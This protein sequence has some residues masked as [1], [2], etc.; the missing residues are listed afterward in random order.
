M[1]ADSVACSPTG[2]AGEGAA[3][4]NM[5]ALCATGTSCCAPA[6]LEDPIVM[7]HW[8]GCRDEGRCLRGHA[9]G[10]ACGDYATGAWFAARP[11][12]VIAFGIGGPT[13]MADPPPLDTLHPL[14]D[15]GH[16]LHWRYSSACAPSGT[17]PGEL[18]DCCGHRASADVNLNHGVAK[19]WHGVPTKGEAGA[20]WSAVGSLVVVAFGPGGPTGSAD[21]PPP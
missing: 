7:P 4:P 13:W 2:F 11:R 12:Y 15:R 3:R 17:L 9:V 5:R 21:P 16:P 19:S 18:P 8:K 6:R 1:D 14:H 20:A 10:L